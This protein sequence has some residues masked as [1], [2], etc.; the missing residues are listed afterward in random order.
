VIEQ[1]RESPRDY[2]ERESHY[3]WGKRYL[4]KVVEQAAAPRVELRH[5]KIVLSVRPAS[6]AERRQEVLDE[7]YRR[8]LRDAAERFIAKWEPVIG[9]K[10]DRMFIQHMKTKW[11]S[12][13]RTCANIRL[14]T[15][16]AKK[17][18][19]CLEYLVVHE[20]LHIVEPTHNS[21]FIDL[22]DRQMPNWRFYR[23]L[24]NRL[25]VRHETWEY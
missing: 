11:G 12:C 15:D 19:E 8:Q 14:N 1:E 5:N 23:Q 18:Q 21:H 17:P 22:M 7:W 2:V 16:L 20:M 10:V 24:L 25:P 3:L 13:S 4:L 6:T 9:V